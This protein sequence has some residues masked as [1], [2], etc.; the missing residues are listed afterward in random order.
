MNPPSTDSIF[1]LLTRENITLALSIFGSIGTLA[2]FFFSYLRRRKNLKIS[3]I[4]ATFN[5]K[6]RTLVIT[7]TLENRSQLP[8]AITSINFV[9]DKNVVPS[10]EYP[11]CVERYEYTQGN[12]LLD[13]KLFYNMK[14]PLDVHQLSAASSYILLDISQEEF[15]NLSTPLILQV[16]S[17][18]GRVQKIKL[19]LEMIEY[20]Q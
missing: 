14:F 8:I 20:G 19:P 16:Y 18:R 3:I 2:T 7:I 11:R 17:T 6:L 15:E 4:D 10:V 9:C 12:R 5:P 13:R 1:N